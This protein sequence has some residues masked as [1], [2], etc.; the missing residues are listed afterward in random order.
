MIAKLT[1]TIDTLARD[2]AVVDVGGVGY[3]LRCSTRTLAALPPAGSAASIAVQTVVRD[4]AID[5]Y[6]FAQPVER[7]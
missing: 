2:H 6:G 3:Y 5:L 4:D 1:G 7:D